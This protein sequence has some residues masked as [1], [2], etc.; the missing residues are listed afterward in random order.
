MMLDSA[1]FF[2]F[3]GLTLGGA[4]LM[5]TRRNP[6]LSAVWLIV[7]LIGVAG[8]FLLL[9][10]EFLFAAQ[11][12]LYVGGITLLFLFVIMLVN[13]ESVMRVRQ[14]RRSW[15]LVL[16]LGVALAA[17]FIILLERGQFKATGYLLFGYVERGTGVFI[18]GGPFGEAA[19]NAEQVADALFTRYLAP[20]EVASVLLLAAIVGAVWMGQRRPEREETEAGEGER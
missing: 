8:L 17:E 4:V 5:L 14:F 11:I 12:I 7:S 2:F 18:P 3:S 1:F 10:A 13:L 16:V 19:G 20:F 9:G 15:P 6:V